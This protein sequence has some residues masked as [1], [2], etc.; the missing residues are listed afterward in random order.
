MFLLLLSYI[1]FYFYFYRRFVRARVSFILPSLP[2]AVVLLLLFAVEGHRR[3]RRRIVRVPFRLHTTDRHRRAF[4][5]SLSRWQY[6]FRTRVTTTMVRRERRD[7]C[8]CWPTAFETL[9][10]GAPRVPRLQHSPEALASA[11]QRPVRASRRR[12][13]FAPVTGWSRYGRRRFF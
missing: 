13:L 7:N 6:V 3:R 2:R 9:F 10:V 8:S 5:R 12:R 1:Y 4:V 11:V